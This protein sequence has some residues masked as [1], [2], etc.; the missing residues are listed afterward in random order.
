MRRDFSGL[1]QQFSVAACRLRMASRT[2]HNLGAPVWLHFPKIVRTKQSLASNSD[3]ERNVLHSVRVY[4]GSKVR[5]DATPDHGGLL[6]D[7]FDTFTR[8]YRCPATD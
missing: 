7:A 5:R 4:F 1:V 3:F 8:F 2:P 6:T